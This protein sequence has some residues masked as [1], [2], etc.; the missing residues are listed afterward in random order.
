MRT[1]MQVVLEKLKQLSMTEDN[2]AIRKIMTD[3]EFRLSMYQRTMKDV[4]HSEMDKEILASVVSHSFQ[5]E[6]DNI[7]AMLELGRISRETAKEMRHNISLL[8][9]QLKK[10]FF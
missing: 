1:N 9:V 8:E 3:Y 6:R 2:P 7:Q 4:H 5:I 10:D